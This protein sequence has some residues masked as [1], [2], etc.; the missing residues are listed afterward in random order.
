MGALYNRARKSK[1]ALKRFLNRTRGRTGDVNA[2]ESE[3]ESGPNVPARIFRG[4]D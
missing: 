4:G 1:D 3:G 2:N